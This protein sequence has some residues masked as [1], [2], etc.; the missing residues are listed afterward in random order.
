MLV[1]L[2]DPWGL[3]GLLDLPELVLQVILGQPGQLA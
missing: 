1:I 2:Q 3:P